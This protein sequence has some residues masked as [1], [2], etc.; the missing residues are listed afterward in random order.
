MFIWLL[1]VGTTY[2]FLGDYKDILSLDYKQD[3]LD[4]NGT[5]SKDGSFGLGDFS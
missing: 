5:W 2:T 3:L 1:E 4:L